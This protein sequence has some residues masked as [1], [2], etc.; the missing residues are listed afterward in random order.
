VSYPPLRPYGIYVSAIF[1]S[2]F[3]QD[4]DTDVQRAV[5]VLRLPQADSS[6]AQCVGSFAHHALLDGKVLLVYARPVFV[7]GSHGDVYVAEAVVVVCGVLVVDAA[8][9]IEA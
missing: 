9:E 3:A 1:V 5:H 8:L 6:G 4:F 7:Y 2:R